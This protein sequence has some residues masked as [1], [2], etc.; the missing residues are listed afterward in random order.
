MNDRMAEYVE[1]TKTHLYETELLHIYINIINLHIPP[2]FHVRPDQ[3]PLRADTV[4][5]GSSPGAAPVPGVLPGQAQINS[6]AVMLFSLR[7]A[8]GISN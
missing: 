1:R 5:L 2:A 7:D 3:L 8:M 6:H 4:A